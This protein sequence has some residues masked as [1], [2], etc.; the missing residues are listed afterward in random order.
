MTLTT[1][2]D[3]KVM[4]F[5]LITSLVPAG[6]ER[7]VVHLLEYIDRERFAPVCIC[8]RNPVGSHLEARVQQLGVPL[9]FL[10]KGDKMSLE[11]LRKLDAL[12]RQYR[13]VVA[14]THLL[15]LNYAYPLMIRYRTP[16]RVYT[17]HNLAEKDIGLRTAPMVRALAFRYRIG[18]VVPVAI[19]EEVRVS[20][21]KVYGYTNPPLIPNGIPTDEYAPNPDTRAQWRQAHGIEPRA[22]VV[23]HIGR[24]AVQKNHALLVEAFAQVHSDAPL[25]LLLVG[26]GELEDAVREQ[27][28][29]LGLQERVRFLGVRADV[30]AI[31]NA[32]DLFVLSSRWE[33]NPMSVMEALAAGLPVVSTA[34]GGVPELVQEGETGLLVPSEDTGALACALQALVDDPARRQAMGAA[35]RQH[36]IAH[37]DIR[38]TVRMYEELYERLLAR[39]AK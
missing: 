5:Q 31:L 20:I 12:F 23:T 24:F 35:A 1:R 25:Y 32:S 9:Y 17:V 36:A 16:A 11:A 34:V 7:L 15:A 30:P 18:G 22:T 38:H 29:E 2:T 10:G 39:G 6:A 13:P 3:D 4:L 21:Q 26:G 28:V 19:A 33:G 27:V 37:F 14:H 8:L